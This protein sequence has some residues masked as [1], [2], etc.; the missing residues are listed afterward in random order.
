MVM[1][2]QAIFYACQ[3]CNVFHTKCHIWV[4]FSMLQNHIHPFYVLDSMCALINIIPRLQVIPLQPKSHW[5]LPSPSIPSLQRPWTHLH[6]RGKEVW[7]QIITF[8]QPYTSSLSM[9]YVNIEFKCLLPWS[10]WIPYLPL[11]QFSQAVPLKFWLHWQTPVPFVP[12]A[13]TPLP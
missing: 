9:Q 4:D 6:S 8:S 13:H 1:W 7:T 2:D 10:Q 11:W 5:Q 12:S 3:I